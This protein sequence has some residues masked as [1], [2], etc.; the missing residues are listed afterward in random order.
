MSV[1]EKMRRLFEPARFPPPPLDGLGLAWRYVLAIA[2]YA[3]I[4]SAQVT[5]VVAPEIVR[6]AMSGMPGELWP[7]PAIYAD[8]ALGF[9]G[10]CLIHLRRRWPLAVFL[11]TEVASIFSNSITFVGVWAFLSLCSRRDMRR[12]VGAVLVSIAAGLSTRFVPWRVNEGANTSPIESVLVSLVTIVVFALI[13]MYH[14]VRQDR[15]AEVAMAAELAEAESEYAVLAERNR[16]AR[17][18]HDVLAHRI[19]LVS[20]HAGVLAYR[21]DLS[22][23][24]TRSIAQIIQE[25]AHASLTELRSVLS[26]LREVPSPDAAPAAPQPTLVLLPRLLE[27]ARGFGQRIEI[28]QF[29]DAAAVPQLTSRHSYRI[30]QECLTNARKHAP[31][32]TVEVRLAGSP[33][34]G[35]SIRVANPITVVG[36]AGGGAGV[37][38]ARLGLVGIS[39]RAQ[40]LGGRCDAGERGGRFVVDVW[41]PWH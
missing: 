34:D 39:E 30:L 38:G 5:M 35:V 1:G 29:L 16:I 20:M 22:A 33:R 7:A 31:Y 2:G 12:I 3:V 27:E 32:A 36:G 41:L 6:D 37:P 40:M 23:E 24:E 21:T 10:T 26:T 19:S 9:A 25:N 11:A 13:G 18:M 4:A 14:G 17:E 8:L 15:Q 28:D